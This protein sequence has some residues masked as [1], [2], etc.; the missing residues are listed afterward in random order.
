MNPEDLLPMD[1]FTKK[2]VK[3][4]K[5]A[6]GKSFGGRPGQGGQGGQR[7]QSGNRPS[8]G[9]FRGANA[10]GPTKPIYKR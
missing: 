7:F 8:G 2:P 9:N 10:G 6:G 1:R 4:P 5:P 3:G